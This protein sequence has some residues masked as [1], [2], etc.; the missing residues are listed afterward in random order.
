VGIPACVASGESA[1][2]DI[3]KILEEA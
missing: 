3:V 1:A 2:D